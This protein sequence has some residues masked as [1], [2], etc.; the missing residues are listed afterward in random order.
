MHYVIAA[1]VA[2]VLVVP[3]ALPASAQGQAINGAGATFPFPLIDTWRVEYKKV[4][5]GV[6]LNYQSIGSGGGVKQFTEKTV[7]FGATDAPL[8]A[9]E[10]D[11][12]P[13]PAV[14][15]P[16]TIG[17]VVAAY[18]VPGVESGLKL[19][20]PILADIY[21]GK[22][23]RWDDPAIVAANPD[24]DMPGR[25]IAAI[26]RSDGSGTTFVWTSY[27]AA[28]SQEW[29]DEVGAGKSVQWPAGRGA[30]GNEGVSSTVSQSPYSIGYVELSYAL[31]TGMDFADIQN[32]AGN[33]VTPTLESTRAA[34]TAAAENLPAGDESWTGVS[35]LDAPGD[36]SYPIASFSYLLLYKEMSTST[37]SAEKAQALAEFVAWAI[38]SAGQQ[39]AEELSYVPLPDAVVQLNMETLALLT[40]DGQQLMEGQGGA[41]QS[42][43]SAEFGGNTYTVLARSESATATSASI[44]DAES[45]EVAFE[46]SGDVELT[47]PKS[48][49]DGITAVSTGG[50]EIEFEEVSSTDADTT[51]RFAVPENA[52][53]EITGAMVVPEFGTV[54]GIALAASIASLIALARTGKVRRFW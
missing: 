3:L 53:V 9:T 27:L 21:L 30:P 52:T 49:I 22:I 40:Y 19:T 28:V 6:D 11:A 35:L 51:I 44:N 25:P 43:A 36:D 32:R 10:E 26:Y 29:S 37:D 50:D 18:N 46:G 8:T 15:I 41:G 42:S 5:P 1:V 54:A 31:T 38:S 48:M 13:S 24:M 4:D 7:D 45:V 20:G 34:V 14:H 33:F 47:L 12:L 23:T 2:L 16:E 17:S 39:H